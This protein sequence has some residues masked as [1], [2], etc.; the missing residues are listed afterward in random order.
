MRKKIV[1]GNWKM[2]GTVSTI[3]PLLKDLIQQLPELSHGRECAV[4]PPAIYLPLVQALLQDSC[5]SWGAQNV[6]PANTGAYT[7][8]LSSTMLN[9]YQCR[10]V[11]V[12]HSER[13]QLFGESE[14]FVADKYHHVKDHG[15]IPVLCVGETLEERQQGKTKDVLTRQILAVAKE[16]SAC[17]GN[18][19]IAYEPVWAIGTGQTAS[20]EQ[21]QEMHGFIRELVSEFSKEDAAAL[22][23]LY[24]GS[25]NDK[26]AASLFSMPDV[27]GGLIGGAS[28]N[29]QQFVEIVKCIN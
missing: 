25:V 24:G 1:A 20:P 11:L 17:F 2:N 5:I 26:N 18:A 14:K 13:R 12:G 16:D 8:E 6:Y 22:P 19:V 4:M 23:L 28:L 3:T 27:D 29:A 7:G 9:D 21:A 15:M 10:Y